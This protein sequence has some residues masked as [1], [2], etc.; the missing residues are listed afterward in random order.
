MLMGLLWMLGM[1]GMMS[2]LMFVRTIMM[3]LG[4]VMHGW[5]DHVQIMRFVGRFRYPTRLLPLLLL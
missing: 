2:G 4:R 3:W 5:M 1:R